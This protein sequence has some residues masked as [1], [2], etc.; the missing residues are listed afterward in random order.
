MS[1][2]AT[3]SAPA[4]THVAHVALT[5][6]PNTGKTTLFN[7]LTGARQRVGNYPGVTVEKKVGRTTIDHRHVNVIDLPG[8]YS[9]CAASADE[10]VVVD[11]LSGH[12][13]GT[14]RPDAIVCVID[15][16]NLTRNLFLASQLA[17]LDLPVVLALN[18]IDDAR[19]Q[20]LVIDTQKLSERLGVPV[21]PT[22]A[23][24]GYGVEDLKRAIQRVLRDKPRM[25]RI[26][27]PA[28][29]KQAFQSLRR[30]LDGDGRESL[31]DAEVARVLFDRD[32]AVADRI[33][34]PAAGRDQVLAEA[35]SPLVA[36]GINPMQAESVFRYR[37]LELQL[38][39]IVA[40]AG[41]GRKRSANSLDDVLTHRVFGLVVF[42]AIMYMVFQSIY[43]F[44]G[45]FM[46]LIETTFSALGEFVAP[47]L[48]S[49]PV[50]QSMVVDGI[51]AGVG[52]VVVFLPQ[53]LILFFFI[54]L[55]EDTGYM[56]R[57][58]FLMDKFFS[59]CGLSGKSFVPMLSSYACAI[60]G[61]MSARTIDDPRSRLTTILISPL[62]SCSARLPVY[63]LLIGAFIEPTYGAA[64]AGFA[65]FAMHFVGLFVAI[66]V[67]FVL[68]R[69]VL[70]VRPQP[71]VL[72]MPPYRV[73]CTRDVLWRMYDRGREFVV[74]AGSVIFAM[75]IVIWAL[76][77]FP[78]PDHVTIDVHRQLTEQVAQERQISV[79]E[80]GAVVD[81]EM[82]D[83]LA[84][85]TDGAYLESSY[86]GRLGQAIQPVFAPA[87]FD[88]K[89]TVGVL[90]SFPAREVIISTLGIIYNLG[91][92]T[93]EESPGLADAMR[94]SRRPD[95]SPV[96]TPVV[97]AAIMVFFALCLQ[98]GATVAIIAR[99]SN[100]KWAL[101][102]FT[103]MTLLAW[104]G[105]VVV[106]Q[107]G[108][109]I[110]GTG[111]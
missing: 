50:L 36:A 70:K 29:V 89:I 12:I 108:T 48:E 5:G 97:A 40:R 42:V 110:F 57:A 98:C 72:E 32:S 101:F 9:L 77:Y 41:D 8:T 25:K 65:L 111:A 76:C 24:T 60:P 61:I 56:A 28:E 45:P 6:N 15:A 23:S 87:G 11:V 69:F 31:T 105:A 7:R 78:R 53:I 92:D 103:Y 52:G 94:S 106:Y 68:N 26:D 58:A 62:M 38:A 18:M 84:Q 51:I 81:G 22:V 63:V 85:M 91:S 55:L 82:A 90:A 37:W 104:C 47:K 35:R 4:Q 1:P 96:F 34:W 2:P 75:S 54:S 73:P 64:W 102:A 27:W 86:M 66:P 49:M 16:T 44:A 33:K 21:V 88:W 43:T 46:D 95:G 39:G 17:E 14:V 30:Q 99:E 67:A 19:A 20:G 74:R 3:A 71:F 59:W 107:A 80:A 93:D 109:A 100:W 83:K 79:D 10:R 13:A